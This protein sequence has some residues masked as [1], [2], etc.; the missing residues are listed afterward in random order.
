MKISR[1]L[2]LQ[3]EPLLGTALQMEASARPGWL[4]GIDVAHPEAAPVLRRMLETHDRAAHSRELETLPKLAP[5][6]PSPSSRSP[7]ERIGPFELLRPLGRGGMGEVWLA[8]QADGRIEREVALKLPG[9]HQQGVAWQ[10]RF[11]RE[12]D[13]LA[14]L[15]H[16]HISRLYDAGVSETGQPWLAMEYVEGLSLIEHVTSRKLSIPGRLALF[17]Q[18]LAA[19]AHAHRHLVVH[20]DLKPANILIDAAGQVK[21]LDFGIARLVEA[22]EDANTSGELTRIGGR[23]MTLRYAAPEQVAADSI[24][25]VTDIYSLGVVLHELVTGLAPYQ[26][27][28]DGK[29]FTD[30]MLL[31]EETSV[32]SRLALTEAA[33]RDCGLASPK[34]LARLVSGDLDAIVLKAMRR[35]PADRYA[36]VELFDE[37][38][39]RHLERRPVKA[40]AG[41]WRYLAGRFAVRHK[42]PLALAAAVLVTLL[43]GLVMTERE[44]RVAV[45]EK[46]RAERHFASVRKLA[47]AFVFDV[48][49][50]LEYLAGSLKARQTLVATALR[51]LDSLAGESRADSELALEVAGAYRRLAE[52]SGDSRGA[53]LGDPVGARRNAERAAALLEAVEAR[54]PDHINV[55]REHRVL[56]LLMGR[57]RLEAGDASGVNETAKAVDIAE[58]ITRLTGAVVGD[59]SNLGA[60]LAEFG[61]ILAVVKDDHEAAAVQLARAIDVLE[62][63]VRELPG[64]LPARASLAYTY[65]RAAMGAEAT[66]RDDQLPRAIDLLTLSIATSESVVR[67]DPLRVSHAQSLVKRYNNAARVH[68]RVGDVHGAREWAS[69]ARALVGRLVAD[70][71]RNVGNASMLAGVLAMASNIEHKG[72]RFE[73]S[74]ELAREAIAADA[75]LPAETRAGLIVRENVVG[76]KRSLAAS[77]CALA[78]TGLQPVSRGMGLVEEA[79]R[80]LA[81]SRSFKRELVDRGIDA[82]EAATAI[83]EIDAELRRCDN[84]M[85]RVGRAP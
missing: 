38:I 46:A 71:P 67:D 42:L 25:T 39:R 83:L 19:V 64:D 17:R 7:G 33:A 62:A 77:S 12:R 1:E 57:L 18:V 60:T 24:T 53:H 72:G 82:R 61:G 29:P 6:P 22:G 76:A 9:S 43:A 85:A 11:R 10:E 30:V 51:Y 34:Q 49:G 54:E 40:R 74:I 84:A 28:R 48:H 68:L 80:L 63:L 65:E 35:D 45:A 79:R 31:Q 5:W 66:G 36:Y 75:R 47:N 4:A 2:W 3:V 70:D 37:D 69:K 32:P 14:K 8:R 58:R 20:R 56:A 50:E 73:R 41:T 27:V 13:I 44:R 23:M 21:L 59:R 26:A 16:P 15:E 52:I 78:E 55:L 81:E